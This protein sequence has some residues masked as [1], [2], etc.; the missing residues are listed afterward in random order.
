MS[1]EGSFIEQVQQTLPYLLINSDFNKMYFQ[2][3]Y[4]V[5]VEEFDKNFLILHLDD[6]THEWIVEMDGW[7]LVRFRDAFKAN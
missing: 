4:K 2:N 3:H 7:E 1:G 6:E 5:K